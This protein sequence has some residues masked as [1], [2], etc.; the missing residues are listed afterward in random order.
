MVGIFSVP[1]ETAEE[2]AALHLARKA[3]LRI[4]QGNYAGRVRTHHIHNA[5]YAILVD[6]THF[7]GNAIE[8]AA[9]DCDVVL[10]LGYAV[11]D[12]VGKNE[13][14]AVFARSHSGSRVGEHQFHAV[15]LV[16]QV[17]HLHFE[18]CV[19]VVQVFVYFMQMEVR[20]NVVEYTVHSRA[21]AICRSEIYMMLIGIVLKQQH[22]T[23]CHIE[24]ED[25]PRKILYYEIN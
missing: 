25:K 8:A 11:A 5:H 2:V 15:E 23:D 14:E 7:G 16:A 6:Y 17:Y 10:W 1:H 13:V 22:A 24:N 9:V 18:Q 12:D 21:Y 19:A 20:C 3:E 4:E